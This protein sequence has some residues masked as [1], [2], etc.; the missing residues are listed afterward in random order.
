MARGASLIFFFFSHHLPLVSVPF[1]LSS[2]SFPSHPFIH[3]SFLHHPTTSHLLYSFHL[4]F[5][6]LRFCIRDGEGCFACH[7]TFA[8]PFPSGAGEK[9][10]ERR[11]VRKKKRIGRGERKGGRSETK[12]KDHAA[13]WLNE[14]GQRMITIEYIM[15]LLV[16][17]IN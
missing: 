5:V 15:L 6:P 3:T 16:E 4:S 11:G 10:R 8:S 14:H 1:F 9:E 13:S 2:L 7:T 12:R 17:A